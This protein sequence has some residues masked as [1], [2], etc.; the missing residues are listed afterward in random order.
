M[1]SFDGAEICE[2]VGLYMLSQLCRIFPKEDMGV[3]RDDGLSAIK[4]SGPEGDRARKEVEQIF[5]KNGLKA[6]VEA[7]TPCTDH[8]DMNLDLTTG[9]FWPFRKPNSETLYV[10][11]KSNHPPNV[12]KQIPASINRRI[13]SLSCDTDTFNNAKPHYEQ[14]LKVSGHSAQLKFIDPNSPSP[15]VTRTAM[16]PKRNAEGEKSFG[17]TRLTIAM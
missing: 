12:I 17:L 13:S 11:T 16:P 8:L 7:L 15:S 6:K 3:Y 5:I 1:G 14:A 10:N 2:L 9:K 4:A